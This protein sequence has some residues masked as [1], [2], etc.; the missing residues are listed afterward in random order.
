MILQGPPKKGNKSWAILNFLWDIAEGLPIWGATKNDHGRLAPRWVPKHPM[1]CIYFSQEDTQDDLEDRVTIL[2]GAGR[3]RSENLWGVPK[4]LTMKFDDDKGWSKILR[5]IDAIVD[6][7]GGVDVIA[8]DPMRRF[9]N[10]DENSSEAIQI[11]WE[12]RDELD[13]RYNCSTLFAHH[14]KKPSEKSDSSD[15][16]AGRGSGDIVGAADLI[17]TAVPAAKHTKR[18]FHDVMY[19][20]ECKRTKPIAPMTFRMDFKTGLFRHLPKEGVDD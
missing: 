13:K 2:L 1:R 16:Y 14:V 20:F 9:H 15:S 3:Q 12:R 6:K 5:N 17:I 10:G 11:L 4:D 19:H 18:S 8:F 7:T